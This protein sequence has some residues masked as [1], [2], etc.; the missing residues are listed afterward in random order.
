MSERER[1][2]AQI[3]KRIEKWKLIRTD[4]GFEIIANDYDERLMSIAMLHITSTL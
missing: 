3:P 2:S 1:E 4:I